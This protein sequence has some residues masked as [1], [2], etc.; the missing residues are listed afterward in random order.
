MVIY[1]N[2][3]ILDTYEG[4]NYPFNY[5]IG[6]VRDITK[7][8]IDFSKTIKIPATKNNN[9][10]FEYF[11]NVNVQS[12][13]FDINQKEFIRVEENGN[14][15]FEGFLQLL[16]VTL[17]D[18]FNYYEAVVFS[19]FRNI[20]DIVED[21]DLSDLDF[22]EYDHPYTLDTFVNSIQATSYKKKL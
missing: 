21:L 2:E 15:V 5:S 22:S 6:D 3:G 14:I 7:R 13:S 4:V 9:K 10:F 12:G 19:S 8:N 1:T 20:L 17:Q 11:Y 16:S 18:G